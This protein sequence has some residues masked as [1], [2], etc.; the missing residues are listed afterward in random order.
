MKI[1]EAMTKDGKWREVIP[2]LEQ[3]LYYTRGDEE[4]LLKPLAGWARRT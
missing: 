3:S 2:Y 1:A 4:R